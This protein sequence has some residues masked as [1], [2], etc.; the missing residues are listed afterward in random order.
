MKVI[1]IG[2]GNP[3]LTDDAVGIRISEL[4]EKKLPAIAFPENTEIS[5]RQNESGG[6]DILDLVVDYDVL[7]LIDALLDKSLKPGELKW[8]TDKVFTSIRLSGVHNMDVFSAIEYGKSLKL[9]VPEKIIVL[10]IG[11]KDV[12]T[13]SEQCSSEVET[14]IEK[15]ADQVIDKIRSIIKG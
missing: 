7:I 4:L 11:V 13:F 8:Y 2:L 12:L 6:W 5:I 15:G 10:G 9:K 1:V 3:I 14:A